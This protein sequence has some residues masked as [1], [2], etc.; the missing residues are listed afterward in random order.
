VKSKVLSAFIGLALITGIHQ[1]AAIGTTVF[2]IETNPAVIAYSTG[3]AFDGTNYLVEAVTGMNPDGTTNLNVQLISPSG[4]LIGSP[5]NVGS[6]VGLQT[7]AG[8][9]FGNTNYL[10]GWTD[11]NITSG[12]DIFGQLISR[13]GAEV[14]STFNLLAAQGVHGFQIGKALASD[15]TNYLVVWQDGNDNSIWG[16]LVTPAGTLSG[17]EFLLGQPQGE[18]SIAATFG[19]TNYLVVAQ[20]NFGGVGNSNQVFG[21]FVSRSG[22]VGSPFQISVTAS[23]DQNFLAVAFDGTNYLVIWPWDPGPETEMNVTNWEFFGRLVSQSGT[24]PGSELALITNGNQVVPSLAFDGTDYLLAYGFDSNTTN[25][26]R[27]LRCQFLDRSAN[28]VGPLFTPFAPQG[29]NV[30]LFA[31]HGVLFDGS[32]FVMA[33][34]LGTFGNNGEVYGAFIPSST[35]S[36]ILIASNR[37]GIQFPL[38]L[39]GTPGI[40]YIIQISTNLALSNWTAIVT[41]SPTNGTFS[42]TDPT[43]TNASRF[44]R[45]VKQ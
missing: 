19:R 37:V 34:T 23:T 28:L 14:G 13:S 40:N 24:L 15:G 29:T 33:A 42:F 26:D 27:D 7:L 41:N 8:L 32:R 30:P 39:T 22:S 35:A 17:P 2:P 6:G 3:I 21:E 1:T 18:A 44:Y 10:V 5:I 9:C 25:S 4:T 43:A 36:P 45:A 16:Q 20:S 11:T 31:V 38:Q 12:V